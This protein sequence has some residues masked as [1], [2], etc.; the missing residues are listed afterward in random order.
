M[1]KLLMY[2]HCQLKANYI[3]SKTHLNGDV[4]WYAKLVG[5]AII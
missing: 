5:A 4:S 1:Q 3:L 2:I